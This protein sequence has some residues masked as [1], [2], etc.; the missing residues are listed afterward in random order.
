M[1]LP[2]E[3]VDSKVWPSRQVYWEQLGQIQRVVGRYTVD[4]GQLVGEHQID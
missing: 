4:S 1:K 2:H 3:R